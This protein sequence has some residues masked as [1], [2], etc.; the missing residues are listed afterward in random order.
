MDRQRAKPDELILGFGAIG[1]QPAILD[2]GVGLS[3]QPFRGALGFRGAPAS[4]T[5]DAACCADVS[6]AESDELARRPQLDVKEA[7]AHASA[8]GAQPVL[9]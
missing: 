1:N 4:N 9:P 3:D 7:T 8:D 5:C 2:I 6:D